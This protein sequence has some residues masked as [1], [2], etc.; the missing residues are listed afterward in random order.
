MAEPFC[1]RRELQEAVCLCEQQRCSASRIPLIFDLHA[2]YEFIQP[3]TCYSH[4][5]WV[6]LFVPAAS[7]IGCELC[8]VVSCLGRCFQMRR[9]GQHMTGGMMWSWAQVRL[10]T[11]VVDFLEDFQVVLQEASSSTSIL[12]ECPWQVAFN[13]CTGS[14]SL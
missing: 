2:I 5:T 7:C 14:C 8:H 9:S 13:S 3:C 11:L 1:G 4:V 12:V 10:V 6:P